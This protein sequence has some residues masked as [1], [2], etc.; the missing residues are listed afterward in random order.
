MKGL[1]LGRNYYRR[2]F[3]HGVVGPRCRTGERDG[4][5]HI[6]R[7]ELDTLKFQISIYLQVTWIGI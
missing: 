1:Y 3:V 2:L 5:E 4:E 6:L 7:D